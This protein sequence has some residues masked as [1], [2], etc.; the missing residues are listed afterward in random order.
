MGLGPAFT[1]ALV[2]YTGCAKRFHLG[3]GGFHTSTH[4]SSHRLCQVRSSPAVPPPQPPTILAQPSNLTP[5]NRFLGKISWPFTQHQELSSVWT[6][7]PRFCRPSSISWTL[8]NVQRPPLALDSVS[9]AAVL[10]PPALETPLVFV[11]TLNT[12][13]NFHLFPEKSASGPATRL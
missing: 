3:T 10:C 13:V 11:T 8:V 5:S 7:S 2:G 6:T 1:S 9:L 12:R 4:T